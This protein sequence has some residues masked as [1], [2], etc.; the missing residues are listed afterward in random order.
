MKCREI[1]ALVVGMACLYDTLG[2]SISRYCSIHHRHFYDDWDVVKLFATKDGLLQITI[3]EPKEEGKK[4]NEQ[5]NLLHKTETNR[6]AASVDQYNNTVH[7]QRKR[8]SDL[9]CNAIGNISD[10]N[11]GKSDGLQRKINITGET[12]MTL[13]DRILETM[14]QA[15]L[16]D[17]FNEELGNY[18]LF[19]FGDG[20][21]SYLEDCQNSDIWITLKSGKKHS[22]PDII[23]DATSHGEEVGFKNGFLI[24]MLFANQA[25]SKSIIFNQPKENNSNGYNH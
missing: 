21:L 10:D 14:Y 6:L 15:C 12:K 1:D 18:S 19:E 16:E 9:T 25:N 11:K 2:N 8:D 3:E 4:D 20:A 7:G 23:S 22:I 13:I 17:A 5:E 24:G